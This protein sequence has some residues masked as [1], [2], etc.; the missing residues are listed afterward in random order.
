FKG[1]RSSG[2]ILSVMRSAEANGLDCRK[3]LEYL[4]TE[5]PNLSVPGGSKALQDY[6]PWSS[7]VRAICAR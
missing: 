3:Y 1:A 2:I 6:L 5:L 4:F 7:Q